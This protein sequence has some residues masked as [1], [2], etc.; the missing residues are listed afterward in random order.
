[1]ACFRLMPLEN[2][3]KKETSVMPNKHLTDE[4]FATWAV[5]YWVARCVQNLLAELAVQAAAWERRL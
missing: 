1:M 3:R 4:E 5:R 2:R